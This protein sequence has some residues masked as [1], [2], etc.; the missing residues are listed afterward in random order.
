MERTVYGTSISHRMCHSR[1]MLRILSVKHGLY[2]PVKARYMLSQMCLTK[3]YFRR[4]GKRILQKSVSKGSHGREIRC[5][6]VRPSSLGEVLFASGSEDTYINFTECRLHLGYVLTLVRDNDLHCIH[7]KKQHNTGIQALAF[8]E[9]GKVLVSSAGQKEASLSL[10]R[11]NHTDIISLEFGGYSNKTIEG[12]SIDRDEHW[13]GDLR[14]MGVDVRGQRTGD[15][16][17]YL[18]CLV[19]SDSSVKVRLSIGRAYISCTGLTR[20]RRTVL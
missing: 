1:I 10:L 15:I 13:G 20:R 9:D 14:I 16:D 3:L 17:V 8:S 11:I 12:Y 19:L 4:V 2:T 6:A 18:V 5:M 7:R